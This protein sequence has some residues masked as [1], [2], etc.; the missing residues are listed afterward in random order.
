[1]WSWPLISCMT[2]EVDTLFA[3]ALVPLVPICIKSIHSFYGAM[4]YIAQTMFSQNVCPSVMTV[5]CRYSVETVIGLHIINQFH[6]RIA[7]P[8]YF[9]YTKRLW[10]LWRAPD[11]GVECKGVWQNSDF[12]P[13]SR[14]LY[15]RTYNGR[16]IEIVYGLRNDAIFND[17]ERPQTKTS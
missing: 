6:R 17:L 4:P 16:K 2:S 5:M 10:I 12:R 1:M 7:T 15:L 13:I 8:S 3:L 9:F 11:R 14:S